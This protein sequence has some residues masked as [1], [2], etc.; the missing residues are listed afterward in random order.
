[1]AQYEAP[2]ALPIARAIDRKKQGGSPCAAC[3]V[4]HLAVCS[5]LETDD[6]DELDAILTHKELNAGDVLF[7]EG[8]PAK[9]VYNLTSGC[10]KLYKLLPDGRRQITGFLF[11]GDFVGLAN[12]DDY[13]YSAEAV[14][15]VALC[16]FEKQKLDALMSTHV[17]LEK[18]LLGMARFELAEAQEQILLLGRKTA[19]ERIASFILMLS[20]RA[21]RR[22]EPGNP[23]VFP[24]NRNDIGDYLGLTTETVSRTM[25]RLRKSGAITLDSDRSIMINKRDDLV[26]MAD[27]F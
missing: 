9:N 19:K 16:R 24:M 1:M 5:A 15:D 11:A 23:V 27:G 8:E 26:D 25:T 17:S 21:E 6:L 4:R 13:I 12:S 22:G 7:D 2:E 14:N 18:R 10:L 20:E 3:E